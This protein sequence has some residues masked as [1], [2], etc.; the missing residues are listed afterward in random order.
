[1]P[2]RIV[3]GAHPTNFGKGN[4]FGERHRAYYQARAR[5]GVGMIVTEALTVHPLDLPYEHAPRGDRSEI[6]ASL[7]TLVECMRGSGALLLA[8]LNHSG[9]QNSG[10]LLRQS[11]WAPSAIP[12]VASRRVPRVMET[13]HI[14]EVIAGFG[15]AASRVMKAGLGGVEVNA[16]QNSLLR[17]F[18]SPLTNQRED[19]FGGPLENRLRFPLAVLKAVREAIGTKGVLGLKLCGDELAPWGGLTPED[20][21]E[22][23]CLLV[24]AVTLDY[25]SI[26]IGGPYSAHVT[27]SPMPAP[28]AHGAHLAQGVREALA[29][30]ER[31]APPVFAEGRIE[32]PQVAARVLAEGQADAVVMTRALVSDPNLPRKVAGED[33]E[34]LRPH[35]GMTRYFSVVGDWNRPLGDLANPRAG[36]EVELPPVTK[37][38]VPRPMLVIGGGPAGMEAACTLARQGHGV[39]LREGASELGGLA[40]ALARSVASRNEFLLLVDYYR[41][42]LEQ[43]GVEIQ[44]GSPVEDWEDDF[45]EFAALWV[46]TGTRA[47]SPE[48]EGDPPP[49]S[50]RALLLDPGNLPVPE[51]GKCAVIDKE[52][53]YRM[54]NAVEW[55]L[56]RGYGVEV[57]T[58]DLFVGRGLV[59]SSDLLWHGRVAGQGTGFHPNL[60]AL[61]HG[62]GRLECR[63]RFSGRERTLEGIAWSVE[64]RPE[65]PDS[66]LSESLRVWHPHV[67]TLGDARAPRL[68]G[69]AILQAHRAVLLESPQREK[70][71]TLQRA[72][73]EHTS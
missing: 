5:G 26:Q 16:G 42:Q 31:A 37:T 11:P 61:S 2:N 54:A 38:D 7:E 71:R 46:A 29:N 36:R 33:P 27:E 23:A 70:P 9:G 21:A 56:Q 52:Y 20:A 51:K 13:E 24:D 50:P 72:T 57:V 17:Q 10:K 32:S 73:Q 6:V 43:L 68:M 34:P 44:T 19:E 55:L 59:E 49:L 22:I 18:L 58:D 39:T 8:Q 25:L 3:F 1:M 65:P 48:M 47:P 4:V 60:E 67:V 53:G 35:I 45:T 64:A 12:D 66:A 14:E 30:R 28:Q 40:A 62:D 15:G 63:E 69:E 41:H